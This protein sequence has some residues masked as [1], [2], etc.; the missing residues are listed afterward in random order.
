MKKFEIEFDEKYTSNLSTVNQVSLIDDT[1]RSH[2]WRLI[3]VATIGYQQSAS[4]ELNTIAFQRIVKTI[5]WLVE[6]FD[7]SFQQVKYGKP[8]TKFGIKE[9]LLWIYSIEYLWINQTCQTMDKEKVFLIR[10]SLALLGSKKKSTN[11]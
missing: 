9:D 5:Q 4:M 8:V 7:D 2:R 10:L 6:N 1:F 11:A 3:H